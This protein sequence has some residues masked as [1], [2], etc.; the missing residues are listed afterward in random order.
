MHYCQTSN[1]FDFWAIIQANWTQDEIVGWRISADI[2]E[3]L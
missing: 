2:L 1:Y 3:V